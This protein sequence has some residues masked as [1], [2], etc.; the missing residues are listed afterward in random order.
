ME[1]CEILKKNVFFILVNLSQ[2][3]FVI[4]LEQAE[5]ILKMVNIRTAAGPDAIY[6]CTLH[7]CAH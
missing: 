4:S 2:N 3:H 7:Y 1:E 6:A 5:T